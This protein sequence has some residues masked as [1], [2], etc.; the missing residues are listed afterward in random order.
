[1]ISLQGY[2]MLL[3]QSH[4]GYGCKTGCRL[5]AAPYCFPFSSS[6]TRFSSGLRILHGSAPRSAFLQVETQTVFNNP[7]QCTLRLSYFFFFPKCGGP[8]GAFLVSNFISSTHS[9]MALRSQMSSRSDWS[10]ASS[11]EGC[12][13]GA[14]STVVM[15]SSWD[16]TKKRFVLY[17]SD[18]LCSYII[19]FTV[20]NM[21]AV[22]RLLKD[23]SFCSTQISK[24]NKPLHSIYKK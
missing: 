14:T 10:F 23:L 22:T 9:S 12:F 3:T 2:F 7:F 16:E 13:L 6:T 11:L 17:I 1:M 5:P 20:G 24:I 21:T 15:F 8:R 19:R 4:A 18:W